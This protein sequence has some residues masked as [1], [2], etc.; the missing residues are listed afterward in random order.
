MNEKEL[1]KL[2]EQL[3]AL[4]K[5]IDAKL[6]EYSKKK[7][8][9]DPEEYKKMKGELIAAAKEAVE[10][11][12]K[13]YNSLQEQVDK[14]ETKLSR[15]AVTVTAE[16]Q[17]TFAEA[18][19]EALEKAK[20]EAK[21]GDLRSYI[22]KHRGLG[23]IEIKTAGADMTT[24]NTLTGAVVQPD[25]VPGIVFDPDTSFR[26]RDLIAQGTTTSSS[27]TYVYESAINDGTYLTAENQEY[28]QVDVDLAVGTGTVRKLTGYVLLSEELFEDVEGLTS[29]LNNRL[30]SKLKLVENYQLLYGNG[31]GINLSGLTTNATAY[32]D[33]LADADISRI[34][35]L[36]D[37]CRQVRD[38][39]YEPTFI[40]IHPTDA[41]QI[42]L[43]KDDNGNYIHPWIFMPN[44]QIV[45]DG[46]PVYVS[47]AITAGQFLVG[48]GKRGAQVFDRRQMAIEI[49]YDNEDNFVKGMVT[50]RISE[51]LTL[52]VYRAKAFIYGSFTAAL[53]QGSA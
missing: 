22:R 38:D 29:Y 6:D 36:V 18:I 51:R 1:A 2:N 43:T 25:R 9:L 10:P 16:K 44:G 48:D 21:G 31:A 47:T 50:V 4:S 17:M 23:D 34:D 13:K 11:E 24:S 33:N 15:A 20:T 45:L 26:V 52:C 7:A 35:V 46:I 39:E 5:S 40:L 42:K 3:E 41:T 8:N 49:S 37:A 28:G 30:A 14:L 19:K 12:L 27:V 53:A 32:S